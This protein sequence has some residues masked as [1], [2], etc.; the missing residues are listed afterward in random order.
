MLKRPFEKYMIYQLLAIFIVC[1]PIIDF[2]TSLMV[3]YVTFPLTIGIVVRALFMMAMFL[4]VMWYLPKEKKKMSVLTTIVILLYCIVFLC[5]HYHGLSSLFV[6]VKGLFKT[7]YFPL[8]LVY[9]MELS[10]YDEYRLDHRYFFYTATIYIIVIV[11]AD[12]T[13]TNFYSYQ[14]EKLGHV[15]WFYAANEIGAILAIL[16]P[17]TINYALKRMPVFIS[18]P[19]IVIYAYVVLIIGTKVPYLGFIGSLIALLIAYIVNRNWKCVLSIGCCVLLSLALFPGSNLAQNMNIHISSLFPQGEE[20]GPQMSR[21]E[22]ITNLVLSSRDLYLAQNLQIFHDSPFSHHIMGI[23]Y[24]N[25]EEELKVVEID[26]A[27]IFICNGYFGMLIVLGAFG[28]A[29]IIIIREI[30]S[31]HLLKFVFQSKFFALSVGAVL[32]LGVAAMAG[33]VLTAPAVSLYL[34]IYAS[35]VPITIRPNELIQDK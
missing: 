14:Y 12:I 26:Y 34:V 13:H 15:G 19:F 7:F 32:G 9:F 11:L 20:N 28:Y 25:H 10:R 17:V 30:L 31:Q 29:C 22:K 4:Y 6:N 1:Q 23:G 21:E 5:I 18:V 2:L 35:Q 24:L 16:S 3:R 27:D 8:L 33:H